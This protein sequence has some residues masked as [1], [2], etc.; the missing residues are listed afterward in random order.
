M[1]IGLLQKLS[2]AEELQTTCGADLRATKQSVVQQADT[3]PMD[4]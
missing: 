4:I 1:E 3:S 2:T